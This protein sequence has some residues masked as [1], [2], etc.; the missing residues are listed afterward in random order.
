MTS[1]DEKEV[2]IFI[3][4]K[5]SVAE[6]DSASCLSRLENMFGRQKVYTY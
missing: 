4:E 5:A 3:G 2:W 6:G 1:E